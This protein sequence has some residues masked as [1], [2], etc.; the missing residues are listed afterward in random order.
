[1]DA[2]DVMGVVNAADAMDDMIEWGPLAKEAG[3]NPEELVP[4]L[5]SMGSPEADA[6]KK[7]GLAVQT[8]EAVAN[9]A[10]AGTTEQA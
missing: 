2:L 4:V 6:R 8:P 10:A 9:G 5:V 3:A 7:F 1:V